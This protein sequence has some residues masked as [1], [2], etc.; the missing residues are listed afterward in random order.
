M[1]TKS[2]NPSQI[3]AI[4][5]KNS[6]ILISA[7]A[8]SGKT[9]T[10]TERIIRKI[11]AGSDIDKMLVVTFTKESANDLKNKI[12]KSIVERMKTANESEK[13]HLYSQIV[14]I[15]GAD[16]STIH[17]FCLKVIRPNFVSLPID[18]NFRIGEEN[19]IDFIK[20]EVMKDVIEEFYESEMPSEEF[21]IVSDCFST[22]SNPDALAKKLLIL[23]DKLSSTQLFLDTLL[24]S[25]S[26]DGDFME[27]P[28]GKVIN[29]EIKG[30]AQHY[31]SVYEKIFE[32]AKSL[33]PDS[34][35]LSALQKDFD[36]IARLV[37]ATEKGLSY[38]VFKGIFAS[39]SAD[40]LRGI[41]DSG[42]SDVEIIKKIRDKLKTKIK[43]YTEY[44]SST[45]DSLAHAYMQN[46]TVCEAMYNILSKFNNEFIERKRKYG[47]CDFNDIERYTYKLLCQ[48][49]GKPTQLAREI[50]EEYDEIYI[51]EYQD[52]NSLQ[53]AIFASISKSNRF[54]VGDIKQSI[55]RF[56][57]A[58][59]E[60]FS[61]YRTVFEDIT[62]KDD[63]GTNGKTIFMSSN[64]RCDK[65][66]IDLTNDVSDY[67]FLNSDGIP[68]QS[69]DRLGFE[70]IYEGKH[71]P[72]KSEI[73]IIDRSAFSEEEKH[74]ELQA[75]YVAKRIYD[76]IGKERLPSGE[77]I[78][79]S[80]IAILLRKG[81]HKSYYI[82]ALNA[83]G[84][85]AEYVDN[86]RFFEKPHVLLLLSL[87]NVIDNPYNDTYLAGALRSPVFNFTFD[88]LL[89]IR[90][91]E[92][93]DVPL[94]SA[95]LEFEGNPEIERKIS[96]FREK[97]S[98]MQDDV[99]KMNAYEA[100]SY[101][102]SV[103]GLISSSRKMER[104]DLIK[105]YNHA[106]EYE[107]TSYK[108]LYK[109]LLYIESIKDSS[110]KDGAFASSDDSIR[111]MSVHASKGLEF[112]ICFLSNL[113]TEFSDQDTREPILFE[114]HLGIASYV[115]NPGS[116]IKYN[117]LIRKSVALAIKKATKDEEMRVLY[118]ALTRARSKIIATA[119]MK[120]AQSELELIKGL[121]RYVS[122]HYVYSHNSHIDYL[123]NT[124][125][126]KKPD[127]D[128]KIIDSYDEISTGDNATISENS[129][130][131]NKVSEFRNIL[132][133][134]FDFKY[135]YGYLNK[136]PSKVSVSRLKPNLLD[137][138]E[139]DEI[140][141]TKDLE[142][143]PKF[144]SNDVSRVTGSERGTATHLFM[145]FCDFDNLAINGY[146]NELKRLLDNSFISEADAKIIEKKHIELFLKSSLFNIMRDAK[147]IKREFR[148]N[149]LLDANEFSSDPDLKQQKLL[150]QGVIDAVFEDANGKLILVD[151]KTDKVTNEN[152][153][154]LLKERYTSQLSYYKKAIELIFEKP[155]DKVL[156]YSVPLS[157][158]VKI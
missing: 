36:V 4:D 3:K 156:I 107:S 57:S 142:L 23:Y 53:D 137:G 62:S 69:D 48:P 110:S 84:I 92:Q 158:T 72:Q 32:N 125:Y 103:C 157:K 76:M 126:T 111:I 16:I 132:K 134:R 140:D 99:K 148:F 31:L 34:P 52:T 129:L 106:R 124:Y 5:H 11:L 100:V 122:K 152:Y 43:T 54:M 82:D 33:D 55:Y 28:F 8:G 109:F 133:N 9:A 44:F 14:K 12:Q 17:S 93:K 141:L 63:E 60:I 95:L 114:R 73:C 90:K 91:T 112:E 61:H 64:Y 147:M 70:K 27:S 46:A 150:V 81:R 29:E 123:L 130:D 79:P 15:G 71:T 40:S 59:P 155:L 135:Q 24:V 75:K 42:L 116:L 120:N 25:K 151:Y 115:G 41:S 127:I 20:S 139:N 58:E 10:L 98:K 94:F 47:V 144:M 68:Y 88:D 19:E 26:L 6:D 128:F 65:G 119:T 101:V 7:G 97:L 85:N 104:K 113:E 78:K 145:Q 22:I 154:S 86:V 30:F 56:R 66:V 45:I 18:N 74:E 87:L 37:N 117:T 136:L 35:V 138:T 96:L 143:K 105:F 121:S 67:M 149:V 89:L 153:E 102:M 2:F 51:D 108:G 131:S 118:V 50:S 21:L 39:Y 146:E 38:E 49:N 77:I 13:E 80:H 1:S 83:L